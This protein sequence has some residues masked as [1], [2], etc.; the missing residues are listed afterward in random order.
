[1]VS[2]ELRRICQTYYGTFGVLLVDYAPSCLTLE[3]V[4]LA[5]H[6]NVSCIPPGVYRCEQRRSP[7]HGLTYRV[8]DVTG[9][10]EILFHA[11]NIASNPGQVSGDTQGCILLG[12]QFVKDE[13]NRAIGIAGSKEAHAR[14]MTM[15]EGIG[16]FDLRVF[17][18]R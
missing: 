17:Q 2:L 5:N 18:A 15:L 4:W 6:R 7:R 14:F 12:D 8:E 11:G 3:D 16:S 9:R 10:S 13:M 1:M